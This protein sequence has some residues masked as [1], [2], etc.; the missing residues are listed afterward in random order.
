MIE[1]SCPILYLTSWFYKMSLV[2]HIPIMMCVY[3]FMCVFICVGTHAHAYVHTQ[4]RF[5]RIAIDILEYVFQLLS[6][7]IWFWFLFWDRNSQRTWMTPILLQWSPVCSREPPVTP[8]TCLHGCSLA[9]E[10][11]RAGPHI[12]VD[13]T[14]LNE[15]AF[16]SIFCDCLDYTFK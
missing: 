12:C 8:C 10:D 14:L 15:W 7:M 16:S 13:I 4:K 6:I 1:N 3:V 5:G 9:A 11:P 2:W